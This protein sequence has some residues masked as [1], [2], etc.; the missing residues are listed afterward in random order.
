MQG[1][2][3]VT[4]ITRS[5]ALRARYAL[6][7]MLALGTTGFVAPAAAADK[8][9]ILMIFGDDVGMWNVGGSSKS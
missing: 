2:S 9:N 8:P 6:A 4:N 7:L 1:I 3:S 5:F